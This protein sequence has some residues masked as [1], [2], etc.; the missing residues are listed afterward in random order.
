MEH[1]INEVFNL[2]KRALNAVE[3][4]ALNHGLQYSILPPYFFDFL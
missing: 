1:E 4:S 2:T 3:R